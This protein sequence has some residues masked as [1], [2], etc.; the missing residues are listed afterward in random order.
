MGETFQQPKEEL[1]TGDEEPW[2]QLHPG[3]QRGLLLGEASLTGELQRHVQPELPRDQR[4]S[5]SPQV[6]RGRGRRDADATVPHPAP[7]QRPQVHRG[8]DAHR[9]DSPRLHGVPRTLQCNRYVTP[10]PVTLQPPWDLLH[11]MGSLVPPG[12][13]HGRCLPITGV[14]GSLGTAAR[15]HRLACPAPVCLAAPSHFAC[16]FTRC[17]AL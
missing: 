12:Q 2:R 10:A 5:Q 17:R 7:H 8:P 1:L 14:T 9:A 3:L 16:F 4:K 13:C 11:A 6:R 15:C